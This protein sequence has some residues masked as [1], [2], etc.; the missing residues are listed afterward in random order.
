V[1]V[2][3]PG[4][5]AGCADRRAA[6]RG[7][8]GRSVTAPGASVTCGCCAKRLPRRKVAELGSTPGIFLCRRCAVWALLRSFHR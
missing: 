7:A 1:G 3:E 6:R 5:T 2:P 4:R 8:A